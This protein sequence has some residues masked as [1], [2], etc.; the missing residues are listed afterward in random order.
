[1]QELCDGGFEMLQ[2]HLNN[3]RLN[4]FGENPRQRSASE[5]RAGMANALARSC[6][7]KLPVKKFA[8]CLLRASALGQ[9]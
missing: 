8:V 6:T 4:V 1:M 7:R 5:T 3:M 9:L 2:Q